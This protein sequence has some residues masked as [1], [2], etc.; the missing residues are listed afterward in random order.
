M[1]EVSTGIKL[2]SVSYDDTNGL[3]VDWDGVNAYEAWAYLQWAAVMLEDV[4][5]GDVDD[6]DD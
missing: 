2:V 1:A 6:G 5:N 4:I 3:E